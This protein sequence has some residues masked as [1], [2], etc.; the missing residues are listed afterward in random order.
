MSKVRIVFSDGS[1]AMAHN[2]DDLWERWVLKYEEVP[3][4][5][6]GGFKRPVKPN[7]EITTGEQAWSFYNESRMRSASLQ[8]S[9]V[10]QKHIKDRWSSERLEAL[11]L[12]YAYWNAVTAYIKPLIGR[13]SSYRRETDKILH[14]IE[15]PDTEIVSMLS[16]QYKK[17]QEINGKYRLYM[18]Y[19]LALLIENGIKADNWDTWINSFE[20]ARR[21]ESK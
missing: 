5:V 2:L 18:K 4:E 20:E 16:N 8:H 11:K 13:W 14:R 3:P 12:E 19:L 7:H 21:N 9:I 15:L 6:S 17:A 10:E 1:R